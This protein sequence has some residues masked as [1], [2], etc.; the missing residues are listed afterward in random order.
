MHMHGRVQGMRVE[1]F[2]VLEFEKGRWTV[3]CTGELR[4]AATAGTERRL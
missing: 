4:L 2:V 1:V 3:G